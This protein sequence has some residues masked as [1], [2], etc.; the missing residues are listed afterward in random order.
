[1]CSPGH[2]LYDAANRP[3]A[4]DPCNLAYL[5]YLQSLSQLYGGYDK[6]ARFLSTDPDFLTGNPQSYLATGKATIVPDGGV[7]WNLSSIDS[8]NFGIKGGLI[9]QLT[10]LPPTPDGTQTNLASYP[11]TMQ[12]VVIP[13]GAAHPDL[14]FA[15]SK[16]TF[17]DGGAVLGCSLSGSPVVRNQQQWLGQAFAGEATLRR[18]AG[19][20]GNPAANLQGLKQQ[21]RLGLLSRASNAINPVDPF[22][23]Q[24]LV[25]ETIRALEGRETPVAAL[26]TVQTRVLAEERHLQY[27]YGAWNW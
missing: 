13:R 18:A 15:V 4:T 10:P 21:P 16:V 11:S 6:L 3:T 22:Y 9:Y 20:P 7:Y 8:Y 23:Q 25:Q 1:M 5:R 26:Q 2:G 12:E 17:W 27:L 24:Q 19:L 14:A